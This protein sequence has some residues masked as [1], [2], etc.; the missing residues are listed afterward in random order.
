MTH[1]AAHRYSLFAPDL[2][3]RSCYPVATAYYFRQWDGFRMA[4][5]H[6][7][8]TEIMYIISGVCRVEAEA[9]GGGA[10]P[11]SVALKKG[12]FIILNANTPHRLIVDEAVPCRMLNIEFRFMPGEGLSPTLQQ[13][14]SEDAALRALLA[15]KRPYLV[16]RDPDEVY[17]SLK[18]LVLELDQQ[19]APGGSMVHMQLMQLLIRI[20]RLHREK[21]ASGDSQTDY[22]VK[23]SIAYM[24]QNYD[25]DIQVK[26]VAAAVSLHPGYLHRIFKSFTG[27]TLTQYLTELRMEKAKMLLLHSDVPILD[28]C[29][30]VGVA[31]RQYFHALFRKYTGRTPAEFRRSMHT[32]TILGL[33]E[34]EDS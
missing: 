18:S 19:A 4:F 9:R 12:E 15:A 2:L 24:H 28:I 13:L 1:A 5:H 29:D 8:D 27:K 6:H 7:N 32:H 20:G 16:L 11:D 30:Y 25:R 3:A 23:A 34:S 31:S 22:Y 10:A 33:E 21:I 14:A 26:D 17:H